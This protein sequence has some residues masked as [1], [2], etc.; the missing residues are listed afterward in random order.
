MRILTCKFWEFSSA[1]GGR[2]SRR[3]FI[4][5]SPVARKDNIR[6]KTASAPRMRGAASI[7]DKPVRSGA[8]APAQRLRRHAEGADE[9]A[10]HTAGVAKTRRCGDLLQAAVAGLHRDARGL[11]A[12]ALDYLGRCRADLRR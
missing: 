7:G 6:T 1:S 10:A 3:P 2:A 11:Q 5:A 12:Q 4:G 9:G 8:R